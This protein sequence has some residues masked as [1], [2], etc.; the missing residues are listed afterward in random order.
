MDTDWIGKW[1]E[2]AAERGVNITASLGKVNL[3]NNQVD[4]YDFSHAQMDGIGALVKRLRE[5]GFVI[6]QTP[7]S[8]ELLAPTLLKRPFIF[9]KGIANL[10][11]RT[12]AWQEQVNGGSG[13]LQ[14]RL[15]GEL[16]GELQGGLQE[17]PHNFPW[18]TFSRAETQQL[19]DLAKAQS[20]SLNSLILGVFNRILLT[21]LVVGEQVGGWLFPVNMR[22]PIKKSNEHANHSSAVAIDLNVHSN[23]REIHQKIKTELVNKSHWSNWW[24]YHIAKYVSTNKMRKLSLNSAETSFWFGTFSNMGEWPMPGT[25]KRSAVDTS[26]EAWLCVPP[27]TKNYPLSIGLITWYGKLSITLKVHQ[28]ICAD[29]TRVEKFLKKFRQDIF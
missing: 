19:K 29:R 11:K 25:D 21:E 24:A 8:R 2:I 13:E 17:D 1:Y 22:G 6:E 15:Q 12:I 14:G 4:W 16:Q 26:N 9:L 23:A 18:T 5:L 3:E 28:S 20:V 27:G 10:K 7:Q